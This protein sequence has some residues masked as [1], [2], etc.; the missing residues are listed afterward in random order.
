MTIFKIL[1][2]V[3]KIILLNYYH[4]YKNQ[5]KHMQNM[6]SLLVRCIDFVFMY[7][8]YYKNETKNKAVVRALRIGNHNIYGI[9][10]QLIYIYY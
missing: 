2:K 4:H 3:S 7:L 5:G 6:K 1:G 9:V 10:S 8:I